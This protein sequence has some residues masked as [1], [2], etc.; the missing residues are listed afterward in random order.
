M[1]MVHSSIIHEKSA[2]CPRLSKPENEWD[3]LVSVEQLFAVAVD[4]APIAVP[5]LPI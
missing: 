1:V 5:V 4:A 3:I 2:G